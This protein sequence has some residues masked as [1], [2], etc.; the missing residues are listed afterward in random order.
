MWHLV[1]LNVVITVFLT[2]SLKCE[3]LC[4]LKAAY[5]HNLTLLPFSFLCLYSGLHSH[6]DSFINNHLNLH[7]IRA[8]CKLFIKYE[9]VAYK[10]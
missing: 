2:Q 5:K 8:R 6:V 7:R 1:Y 3:Y 4:Y 10:C 9:Y